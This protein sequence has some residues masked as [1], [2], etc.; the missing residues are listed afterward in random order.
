MQND[1]EEITINRTGQPP[2]R[3]K[4]EKIGKGSTWQASK[5]TRW[6]VV[7]IYKTS[8]GKYVAEV[9][10]R[11]QWEGESDRREATSKATPAEVI[12]WLRGDEDRLGKASQEA[13]EQ[14]AKSDPAFAEVW[15]ERVD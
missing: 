2:L 10:H 6:T 5:C 4:G 12:E 13:V 1:I 15:Q 11:T 8:G 14:A 7:E 9:V 3:F